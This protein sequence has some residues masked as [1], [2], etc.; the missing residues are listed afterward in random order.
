MML[1]HS[2]HKREQII[3]ENAYLLCHSLHQSLGLCPNG[4]LLIAIYYWLLL[5]VVCVGRGL[6]HTI[7]ARTL[8]TTVTWKSCSMNP[9]WSFSFLL[10]TIG[11]YLQPIN[12]PEIFIF[13]DL[14]ITK[15][16]VTVTSNAL[17]S[18]TGLIVWPSH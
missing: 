4:W 11:V 9:K 1:L 14:F 10:P 13:F 12:S 6:C 16:H 8:T 7:M 15:T 18:S 3:M 2:E 5:A 17:I